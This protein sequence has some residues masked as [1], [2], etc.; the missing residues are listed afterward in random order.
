MKK[1]LF[2]AT[3]VLGFTGVA[4][5]ETSVT[6]YGL[7]DAGIGYQ[8]TKVTQGDSFTK[9]RDIGLS[10]TESGTAIGGG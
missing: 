7:V 2:A 3:L 10:S 4:N 6:L 8:Q 9:T 1:N 5:A